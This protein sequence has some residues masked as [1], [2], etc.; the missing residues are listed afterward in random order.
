ML[1][2]KDADG[3]SLYTTR[4][5]LIVGTFASIL[6]VGGLGIWAGFT[7]IA[8][9]VVTSGIISVES[10]VK[11][12]Q[13]KEGGIVQE[14]YV[15]NGDHVKSGDV[16]IRL[17]GT[18]PRA[19][20]AV[21][22]K[23]LDE[24]LIEETRLIAELDDRDHFTLPVIF[25]DRRSEQEI[26]EIFLGQTAL[27]KARSARIKGRKRQLNEQIEQFQNQIK[28]LQAQL[29]SKASEMKFVEEELLDLEKL[30][31]KGLV[32]Q[33]RVIALRRSRAQ[34][35]G[36]RGDLIARIAQAYTAISER[37]IQILQI[38]EDN[39]TE[40]LQ[41]TQKIRVEIA[42]L[43]EQKTAAVDQLRR[44]DIKAPYDGI[45]HQL[46]IHT[47]EGVV[48]PGAA[49]MQIVPQNDRL[50]IEAKL[51]P[52]DIDHIYIGQVAH[53]QL[54]AFDQRNTPQLYAKVI[55]VSPNLEQDQMTGA[56]Y[57]LVRLEIEVDQ[58]KRL[59]D[60]L[61]IPGM[62]VEA[63]IQTNERTVLDYLLKPLMDQVQKAFRE[64]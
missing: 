31:R 34:L 7:Y 19:S 57:Y 8:G 23:Q 16:L 29:D 17:D 50:I 45:V 46:S 63:F 60:K 32:S 44:I 21:I 4:H 38:D 13:H 62:P 56:Q 12:I 42:S 47:T 6:L 5:Y 48:N 20:L 18:I 40:V 43:T 1:N 49:V 64:T 15:Q 10:N 41:R 11:T 2:L 25:N 51:N 36:E 3:Q 58:L 61:L 33:S 35:M 22:S 52:I 54:S 26:N 55:V 14:I 27:L 39:Q 59:G 37:R 28:G 24:L 53:V 30:L 9:A